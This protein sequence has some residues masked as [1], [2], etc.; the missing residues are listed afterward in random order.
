MRV[1]TVHSTPRL[2][3][4]TT[5]HNNVPVDHGHTEALF[6]LFSTRLGVGLRED[7]IQSDVGTEAE[8]DE[9]L[10]ARRERL[11][12]LHEHRAYA[13]S[14]CPCVTPARHEGRGRGAIRTLPSEIQADTRTAQT[15]RGPRSR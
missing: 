7:R 5:E 11:N 6:L 13:L 15:L 14:D 12:V 3:Q 4:C 9:V 8:Q 1:H 2:E 10:E